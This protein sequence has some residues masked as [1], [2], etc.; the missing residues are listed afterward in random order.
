M[1][2][3]YFITMVI[4]LIVAMTVNATPISQSKALENARAF[5]SARG[6]SFESATAKASAKAKSRNGQQTAAPAYYIFGN[7]SKFVIAAGDDTMPAVLGY[8]DG[9]TFDPND[10]PE[11]LADLLEAYAAA[12]N[13]DLKFEKPTSLQG[14]AAITPLVMAR[15]NQSAP[16]N[17]ACPVLSSGSR[18]ATGCVAT[19]MAQV[20]SY[21]RWPATVSENIPAY[22]TSTLKIEMPELDASLFPGW[23]NIKDYY[24]YDDTSGP[25]ADDVAMLMLFVG[26]SLEMN[27]DSSSGASTRNLPEV[28]TRYFGY[29]PTTRYLYRTHYTAEQWDSIQYNELASGRPTVLCGTKYGSSGH[30]F[31]CDGYNGNGMFHIN[32]GWYGKSDGYFLLN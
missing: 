18:A 15:W 28:L 24:H 12:A 16:W 5:M 10:V 29:S 31:V 14:C 9:N 30:A 27:Y 32:W 23:S 19:A 8:S 25:A 11:G 26:Q 17:N 6:L 2:V 1:K 21:Y 7:D 4:A 22:T 20:M 3:R 13:G